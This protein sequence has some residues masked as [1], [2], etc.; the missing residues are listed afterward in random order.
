MR[1]LAVAFLGGLFSITAV[2]ASCSAPGAPPSPD[3]AA[4]DGLKA[5]IDA[6]VLYIALCDSGS[7]SHAEEWCNEW[8]KNGG[9]ACR[10]AFG[11]EWACKLAAL[12]DAA[13]CPSPPPCQFE[14]GDWTTCINQY[15]CWPGPCG[16][17]V[18]PNGCTCS[19]QCF[20][21]SV[22]YKTDCKPN[23][24]TWICDCYSGPEPDPMQLVGT[25]DQGG[26]FCDVNV[27]LSCCNQF[28]MLSF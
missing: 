9:P 17:S 14:R 13:A 10:D 24:T 19:K 20:E 4:I 27:D 1:H 26:P 23:G 28:F 15:G 2:L 12:Q 25:C 6:H 11:I 7:L 16:S 21:P 8:F 5:C 22:S 18:D 3:A